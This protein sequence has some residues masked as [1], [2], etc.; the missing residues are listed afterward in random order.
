ML[1]SRRIRRFDLQILFTQYLKI[2]HNYLVN[3]IRLQF[4]QFYV[5]MQNVFH[6]CLAII[7]KHMQYIESNKKVLY[8]FEKF[9]INIKIL[10]INRRNL[11]NE[12]TPW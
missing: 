8:H 9:A 10:N 12:N 7:P 6:N 1:P 11:K 2:K 4:N 3:D 5:H